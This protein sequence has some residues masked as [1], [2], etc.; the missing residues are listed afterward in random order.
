MLR[1]ILSAAVAVATI[2]TASAQGGPPMTDVMKIADKSRCRASESAPAAYI[3]GVSLVFARAACDL[4]RDDVRIVSAARTDAERTDALAW[5]EPQFRVLGMSNDQPGADTLRHAYALLIG[6]GMRESSG[7]YCVGRD[8]SAR[9]DTADSAEAGLFQTS[10]GAHQTSKAVLEPM[11]ARY[12]S[13]Q[14]GCMLEVFKQGASCHPWDARTWGEGTGAEWQ[15]LTKAC[16]AFA[17]EY[18]AVLLRTTGGAKGEFGPIR[19]REATVT[20]ACDAMLSEIQDYVVK[21]PQ[22]CDALRR[23]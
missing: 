14:R 5:Y 2:A 9:F 10:W 15:K 3:R 20:K 21:N 6:L 23:P 22:A 18:A 13:D 11:Y 7:R 8:K 17:T 1:S 19:R 4:A 12:A 16:P